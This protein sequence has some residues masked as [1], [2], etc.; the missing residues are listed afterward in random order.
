MARRYCPRKLAHAKLLE[1]IE[2][3]PVTDEIIWTHGQPIN[4]VKHTVIGK[5]IYIVRG[6]RFTEPEL[7]YFYAT[8]K[9]LDPSGQSN[10]VTYNGRSRMWYARIKIGGRYYPLG[11]FDTQQEALDE[12][13]WA[14]ANPHKVTAA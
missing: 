6:E 4:A 12:V 8:G 1:V 11:R 2:I 3:H 5:R 14:R 10:G 13:D 7:R 9:R